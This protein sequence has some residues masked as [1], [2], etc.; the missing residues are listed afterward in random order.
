MRRVVSTGLALGALIAPAGAADM[1]AYNKAPTAAFSW[2]GGYLGGDIAA[3]ATSNNAEW[4]PLSTS[5]IP[6][7]VQQASGVP[8]ALPSPGAGSPAIIGNSQTPGWPAQKPI[9]RG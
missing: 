7:G 8:V 9:G 3:A 4:S 5:G 1:P 2:T 6:F